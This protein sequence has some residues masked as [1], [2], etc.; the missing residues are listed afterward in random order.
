MMRRMSRLTVVAALLV[1]ALGVRAEDSDEPPKR[2]QSDKVRVSTDPALPP[3]Y[4]PNPAK[5]HVIVY[6]DFQC[7]V[8]SRVVGATHQIAQ[9]FPGDVR[10]EFRQLALAMHRHAE[11]AAVASL[12]AHRQGKFWKMHDV[13]FANQ[14][15]LDPESLP[16]HA[17]AAGLDMERFT[18]DYA[19]AALRERVRQETSLAERLGADGTPTFIIN[20]KASSGWASWFAFRQDVG[21]ELQEANALIKSGVKPAEVHA[22]RAEEALKDGDFTAYKTAVIDPLAKAAGR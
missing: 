14:G 6:S 2:T 18:K 1:L 22:R 3:A 19:D 16:E 8:C 7:P 15:K 5:V 17:R 4:G 12:A 21:T 13:L 20:G 9:E 10:V 11:N